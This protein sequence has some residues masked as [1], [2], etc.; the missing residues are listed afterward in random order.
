MTPLLKKA[1]TSLAATAHAALLALTMFAALTGGAAAAEG[2]SGDAADSPAQLLYREALQSIAEGRRDDAS[3]TLSRVIDLEPLHAGAWLDLALI[4]CTMGRKDEAERLF[5]AI[6]TR[7]DP[8]QEILQLITDAR[9]GGCVGWSGR[10]QY[11]IT[12]ARGIDQNVNQGATNATYVPPGGDELVLLPDF[13]PMHDQYTLLSADYLRD[14]TPNGSV[15]FMQF[16]ARQH[17]RLSLYDN[18]SLV[19]GV[20]TPWRFGAWTARTTATLGA[21]TL[22]GHYYQRQAQVQLN[23]GPPLPLPGSIQFNVNASLAHVDYATL[24]NFRSNT[25]ELRGQFSYRNGPTYAS[26]SLTA[27]ADLASAARPGGDRH[28]TSLALLLRR[29]LPRDM[30]GEVAYYRQNWDSEL[31]YAPGFIDDIR[32]QRTEVVRASLSY[33]LSKRQTLQLEVRQV[34]NRENISIF[35]YNSRQLQLSWQWQSL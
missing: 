34:R 30:T 5:L 35:Q 6:E 25:G 18:L 7:F 23:V 27:Q 20:E 22:G 11:G 31:P 3:A 13:L 1:A 10:A 17:D 12:L 21:I 8:P 16:Q 28:G 4:Q 15:G 19:A 32:S 29:R 14:L 24:S 9:A 33:P 2:A 26:L